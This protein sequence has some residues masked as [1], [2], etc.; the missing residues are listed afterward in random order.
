[1]ALLITFFGLFIFILFAF[2]AAENKHWY[3]IAKIVI[4][5]LHIQATPQHKQSLMM[6]NFIHCE[7][8][9]QK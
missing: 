4:N 1:M 9:F 5:T 7:P 8:N 6:Y 2:R 3:L